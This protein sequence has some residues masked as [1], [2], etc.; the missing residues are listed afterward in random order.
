MHQECKKCN[1][2]PSGRYG[3]KTIDKALG[4]EC[5]LGDGIKGAPCST[6]DANCKKRDLPEP[7]GRCNDKIVDTKL[8]E[9]CDL[10]NG[11][12]GLPGSPFKAQCRSSQPS[13]TCPVCNPNPSF[14]KCTTSTSCIVT[15][16]SC[17]NY[18]ACRAGYRADGL[19][20]TDPKQFWLEFLGQLYKVFV[21]PGLECNTLCTVPFP[22]PDSCKEVHVNK[23]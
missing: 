8:G 16:P 1:T 18:C 12:N 21:A 20:P 10:G 19:A 3:D 7:L 11:Q 9:E 23:C 4:E 13:P 22:G 5:D 17:K 6:C 2:N 15:Q 14:N